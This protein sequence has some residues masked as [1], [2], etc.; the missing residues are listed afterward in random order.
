M[1]LLCTVFF[2][3]VPQPLARGTSSVIPPPSVLAMS[4]TSCSHL[5]SVLTSYCSPSWS[6]HSALASLVSGLF[7]WHTRPHALIIFTPGKCSSREPSLFFFLR[8]TLPG[9]LSKIAIS[10][11]P[12]FPHTYIPRGRPHSPSLC[13]C[14]IL[15]SSFLWLTHVFDYLVSVSPVD[16]QFH[17]GQDFCLSFLSRTWH[18]VHAQSCICW[19]EKWM[20][21]QMTTI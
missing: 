14:I 3:F 4:P 17:W 16:I 10:Q 11:Q 2:G 18:T 1:P 6:G 21:Q 12:A 19:T 7:S 9:D 5:L 13:A 20:H 15:C 8:E